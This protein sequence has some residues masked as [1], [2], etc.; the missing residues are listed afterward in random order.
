MCSILSFSD[1]FEACH[2]SELFSEELVA[3]PKETT[4]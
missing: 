1:A 3:F 2:P 4:S